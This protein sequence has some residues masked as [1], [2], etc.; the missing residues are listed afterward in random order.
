MQLTKMLV[1]WDNYQ[2][3]A[4]AHYALASLVNNFPVWKARTRQHITHGTSHVQELNKAA[5]E[6]KRHVPAWVQ[7]GDGDLV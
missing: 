1:S 5:V 4:I 7:W 6:S 3:I 2:I